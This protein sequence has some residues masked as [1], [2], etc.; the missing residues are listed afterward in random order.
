VQIR[1]RDAQPPQASPHEVE[2][3]I[4]ELVKGH[5]P[6]RSGEGRPASHQ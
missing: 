4:V 1:V 5:G 6:V 3:S 2:M